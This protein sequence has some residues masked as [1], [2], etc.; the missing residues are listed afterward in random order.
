MA[1]TTQRQWSIVALTFALG[2]FAAQLA[3]HRH[4]AH[5]MSAL[6]R[7]AAEGMAPSAEP[8]VQWHAR[9]SDLWGVL[10]LASALLAVACWVSAHASG[11]LAP[12]AA[13]SCL[14]I[15]YLLLATLV[16]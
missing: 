7:A 9:R 14:L 13:M 8:V 4:A 11:E 2:A 16:V 1:S 3:A 5:G 15:A 12:H 6:A 10:G